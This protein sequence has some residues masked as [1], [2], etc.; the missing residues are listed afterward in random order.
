MFDVAMIGMSHKVRMKLSET[1]SMSFT[2]VKLYSF[3]LF[4]PGSK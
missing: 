1:L 2:L 4:F 3:I